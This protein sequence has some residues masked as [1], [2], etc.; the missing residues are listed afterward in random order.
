MLKKLSSVVLKNTGTIYQTVLG[1]FSSANEHLRLLKVAAGTGGRSYM[2]YSKVP[3]KLAELCENI[4]QRRKSLSKREIIECYKLSFDAHFHL[5]TI[6]PWAD[7][8]G[9]MSRLLMNQLQFEFGIIPTNINKDR[10]AE[11]IEALIATRE[12]NDIELFRNFMFDEHIRNLEETIRNYQA[13]IEDTDLEPRIDV[14]INVGID[15]QRTLELI[16]INNRITAKEVAESLSVS[17]RH[18]ERIIATLKEK[19]LIMRVGSNKSG[20]WR[21][22]VTIMQRKLKQLKYIF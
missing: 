10:K 14:G 12:N 2:N 5:V 1:E 11:Y 13:L 22:R 9:R 20:H 15:E 6:H 4:N 7:G 16:R 3:T 19:G 8:N 17:L 18:G 21:Y